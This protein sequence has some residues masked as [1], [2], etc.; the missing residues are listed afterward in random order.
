MSLNKL[1]YFGY[2][3]PAIPLTLIGTTYYLY[4]P[5]LYESQFGVSL[6][7]LGFWLAIGR[8]FDA[9]TDP[10]CGFIS[11]KLSER[12]RKRTFLMPAGAI[13]LGGSFYFLGH[14][15]QYVE[16]PTAI[17]FGLLSLF[18]YLGSTLVTVPYEVLGVQITEDSKSRA[19]LLG[20][21]DSSIVLATL[22]S[23]ILPTLMVSY[24]GQS[25][26]YNLVKL[27]SIY[28]ILVILFVFILIFTTTKSQRVS[29]KTEIKIT[30]RKTSLVESLRVV[31]KDTRFLLLFISFVINSLGAAMP[32][33]LFFF[34]CER[35]L[36]ISE[37]Q[38]NI[39][40]LLYSGFGLLSVPVWLYLLRF[41]NK[42]I[43]WFISQ[44]FNAGFFIP[45]YW[46]SAGDYNFYIL[47]IIL[48]SCGFGGIMILPSII[49]ADIV[50]NSKSA[51]D[52]D[53]SGVYMGLWSVGKKL[54]QAIGAGVALYFVDLGGVDNLR[55]FYTLV[56]A[57]LSI[58]SIT[59]ALRLKV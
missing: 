16:N 34:Y 58:I 30:N 8:I 36:L 14:I 49:Q 46:L 13:L 47:F 52:L 7:L 32:A 9:I 29:N 57:L 48:S 44:I 50:S 15:G 17:H 25:N 38:A 6:T 33:T 21:R 41:Y 19:T 42:K 11:D 45:V 23:A 24:S 2:A 26:A 1:D 43:L 40:L 3:L 59:L 53:F 37:Q 4:L 56:P 35:I 54:S 55:L 31:K 18:M 5:K 10:L 22:L 27:S 39:S 28:S 51:N 12:G 20:L